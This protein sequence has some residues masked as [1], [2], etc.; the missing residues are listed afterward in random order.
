[1]EKRR[2]AVALQESPRDSNFADMGAGVPRPYKDKGKR[3]SESGWARKPWFGGFAV[4]QAVTW[5]VAQNDL[6]VL[7]GFGERNGFDEFGNFLEG[8]FRLPLREAFFSGV[9]GSGGIFGRAGGARQ[10]GDIKAYP[11]RCSPRDRRAKIWCSGLCAA[12]P[13]GGLLGKN[14]HEADALA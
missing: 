11:A 12:W 14:L 9:V 8:A 4:D 3:I 13:S 10:L 2:Q 5:C 1:L 6:D 7:A